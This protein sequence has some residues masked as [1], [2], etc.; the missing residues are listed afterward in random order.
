MTVIARFEVIPLQNEHMSTA[1]ARALRAL[2]RFDVAYETTPT[3][4]V[5]EA[6][7]VA[8]AF[9][10]VQAAHEAIP[11]DRVITS[12]EVDEDRRRPQRMRERVA[13]VERELG[14][15]ARQPRQ[16]AE[17][18]PTPAGQQA[19]GVPP[20]GTAPVTDAARGQPSPNP[21]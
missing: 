10:A 16:P 5:V 13:A 2:D 14:R 11:G 3:D 1:I 12:L 15:P 21:W 18:Q 8:E 4:T 20:G 6:D 19:T 17:G 9:A 7:T